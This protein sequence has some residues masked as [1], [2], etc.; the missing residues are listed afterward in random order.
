MLR[1]RTSAVS[2]DPL[3][4]QGSSLS[5]DTSSEL[6]SNPTA[7]TETNTKRR[8]RLRRKKKKSRSGGGIT[9]AITCLLSFAFAI[10]MTALSYTKIVDR[11]GRN[12]DKTKIVKTKH[13]RDSSP[14]HGATKG[15]KIL[16]K[17]FSQKDL[18]E[19]IE[20]RADDIVPEDSIYSMTYPSLNHVDIHNEHFSLSAFAG[21]VALVINVAS[22]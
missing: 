17:N 20:E 4:E 10:S 22:E 19:I 1:S 15:K 13:L 18:E 16:G 7:S 21:R 2:K 12:M 5:A 9:N 14:R 11:L 8:R 6:G 3:N